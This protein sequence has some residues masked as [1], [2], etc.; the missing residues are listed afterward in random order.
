MPG[1]HRDVSAGDP[2]SRILALFDDAGY[3]GVV[4]TNCEQTYHR[5]LRPGEQVTISSALGDVLDPSRPRWVR[6]G[7]STSTPHGGWVT[8]TSPN[9]TGA[10]SNSRRNNRNQM[11]SPTIWTL[12]L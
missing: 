5:Y 9:R 2:M 8:K 1:L 3:V 7:S 6:D 10:S 11:R 4:A 12:T